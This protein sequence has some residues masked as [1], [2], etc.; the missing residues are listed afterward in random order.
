MILWPGKGRDHVFDDSTLRKN[1]DSLTKNSAVNQS[2]KD[3]AWILVAANYPFKD[4]IQLAFEQNKF[5]GFSSFPVAAV[6]NKKEFKGKE[7]LFYTLIALLLFFAFIRFSFPKY[8][9]DL[10]RVAFR[11]TLKQRQ[12][13][14]QLMQTP[15]PSLLLNFFFLMTSGLYIDF[16]L[17]HYYF[18]NSYNFWLLYLY[19]FVGLSIYLYN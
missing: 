17:Q 19:C 4:F 12:I 7:L 2:S 9:I 16:L 6:S 8:F 11:T 3:T 14:E 1:G 10:F 5:F 13:G 18:S 15:I